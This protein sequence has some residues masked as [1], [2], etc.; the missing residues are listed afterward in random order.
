[1]QWCNLIYSPLAPPPSFAVFIPHSITLNK[2]FG[3]HYLDCSATDIIQVA[4]KCAACTLVG[5]QHESTL[6]HQVTSLSKEIQVIYGA[7]QE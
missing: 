1:M 6:D 3:L 7:E 4:L 5:H 2:I